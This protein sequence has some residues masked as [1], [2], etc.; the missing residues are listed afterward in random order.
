MQLVGATGF[1]IQRPFLLRSG[2]H[3][4]VGGLIAA[5]LLAST[6]QYAHTVMPELVVLHDATHVFGLF[7]LMILVGIFICL[8]ST[9]FSMRRYLR[10]QLD[11]LY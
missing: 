6:L 8:L 1:F 5:I 4:F 7:G 11:D 10:M 3:G 9:A 2:F